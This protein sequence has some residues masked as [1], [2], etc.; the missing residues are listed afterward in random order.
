MT[1]D[2]AYGYWKLRHNSS[3]LTF[4]ILWEFHSLSTP[5]ERTSS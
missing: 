4:V 2:L 5:G 1:P 3:E